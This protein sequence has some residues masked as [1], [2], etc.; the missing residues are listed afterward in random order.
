MDFLRK[1]LEEDGFNVL[2]E[3]LI[4]TKLGKRKPD[5]VIVN[6]AECR[7]V[8]VTVT[9][10]LFNMS[11][12]YHQKISYYNVDEILLWA[13]NKWSGH[14]V[15]TDAIVLNWRGSL[16]GHFARLLKELGV[17]R[18][19]A[20]ILAIRVLTFTHSMFRHY[21]KSTVRGRPTK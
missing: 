4:D 17:T 9:S 16:F 8:D 2:V 5:L 21:Y 1:K 11:T 7:I 20:S 10:D 13:R 14:I 15:S 19:E 6:E 18:H 12:P 3:P